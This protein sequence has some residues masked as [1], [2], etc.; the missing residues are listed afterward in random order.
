VL[1]RE[2]ERH[3]ISW[4]LTVRAKKKRLTVHMGYAVQQASK[5][6]SKGAQNG[7]HCRGNDR[8]AV[9]SLPVLTLRA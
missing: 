9:K 7:S 3:Q 4:H 8:C 6:G 2:G 1:K 5:T